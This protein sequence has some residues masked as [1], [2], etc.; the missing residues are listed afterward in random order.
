MFGTKKVYAKVLNNKLVIRVGGGYMAIGEFVAT[1]Q[2]AELKKVNNLPEE[3]REALWRGEIIK[4]TAEKTDNAPS[5][6]RSSVMAS[7][8][9]RRGSNAR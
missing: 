2:E 6:R 3:Q 8:T 5:G 7:P 9:G 4:V 1:Y